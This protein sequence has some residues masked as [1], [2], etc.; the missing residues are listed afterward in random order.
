MLFYLFACFIDEYIVVSDSASGASSVAY[1]L[2]NFIFDFSLMFAY[3]IVFGIVLAIFC[4]NT[5]TDDGY[6]YVI[7]AGFFFCMSS[8][9]RYYIFS[10]FIDDV[11]LAQSLYFYG[12]IGIVFVLIDIWL[13][14][15]FTSANGNINNPSVHALA[16][17]FSCIDPTFGWY[18][19]ILYQ[20]NF[21]GVITQ[22]SG[23]FWSPAIA[24]DLL[25]MMMISVLIYGFIFIF[26]TENA[27]GGVASLQCTTHSSAASPVK[28]M[29]VEG[30]G[31]EVHTI[32]AHRDIEY[33]K[34]RNS[35]KNDVAASRGVAIDDPDVIA[36]RE[37]VYEI[38]DR[39]V[40]NGKDNAIF[41]CNLR[42]IYYARGSVPSKV[43]VQDINLSIPQGEIF[44]LLGANGAGKTT[45]LKMVSGLVSTSFILVHLDSLDSIFHMVYYRKPLQVALP[46]LTA[47][48][49]SGRR[50][51][52][53]DPWVCA[54]SSTPSWSA[55]QCA[56]TCCSSDA[57]R[58]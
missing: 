45:L 44:G 25:L 34:K 17:V 22:N 21:L 52:R 18:S 6:G 12:T 15:L 46:S 48:T 16:M 20:N 41:I 30:P 1:W 47:T 54:R 13:N 42:K 40:L 3:V 2:A 11:R 7:G 55:C 10:Y 23:S 29:Q 39:G 56:R 49:W 51:R 8:V 4:P 27:L 38:A 36:E 53:S 14:V 19:I 43:A 5:Y 57:S 58:A 9:F 31:V 35:K 37:K 50:V 32:H 28:P 24:G 26:V 33:G